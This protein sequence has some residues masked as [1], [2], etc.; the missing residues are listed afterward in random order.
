MRDLIL[1]EGIRADGRSLT[2][3][4]PIASQ[5]GLLPRTHGSV[6]FTRGE[7]QT[8]A[9]TTLGVLSPFWFCAHPGF[10][11]LP[12]K[13]EIFVPVTSSCCRLI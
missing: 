3:V 11:I 8:I 2:E 10:K 13:V 4:R 12:R 6:L 7:T 1:E 9:V 5:C